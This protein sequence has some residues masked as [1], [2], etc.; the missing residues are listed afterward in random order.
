MADENEQQAATVEAT[1]VAPGRTKHVNVG[2][3]GEVQRFPVNKTV[4]LTEYQREALT[5]AG[6]KLAVTDDESAA[7]EEG[8]APAVDQGPD[9][10][11]TEPHQSETEQPGEATGTGARDENGAP[12]LVGGDEPDP[13]HGEGGNDAQ[14]ADNQP[15]EAAST[16][17]RD[18]L[19]H[20]GDG[21]KGGSEE[22]VPPALSGKTTAELEQIAADE[23]VDL[24][25]ASTNADRIEAIKK[26][27]DAKA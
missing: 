25:D 27:R 9:D 21:R 13:L 14:S 23:G 8:S 17:E 22:Y 26:A 3:N 20:D 2:V 12:V 1:I 15:K 7:G 18:P 16:E 5:N 6:Y 10:N 11:R 19:D 24:T 4:T